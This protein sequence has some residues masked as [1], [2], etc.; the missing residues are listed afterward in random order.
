MATFAAASALMRRGDW[1]AAR[2]M[3]DEA[4]LHRG[5]GLGKK[6]IAELTAAQD[7]LHHLRVRQ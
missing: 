7:A 5:M 2:A 1:K 4:I 6:T 3:V